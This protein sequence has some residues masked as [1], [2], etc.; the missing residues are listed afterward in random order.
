MKNTIEK[1]LNICDNENLKEFDVILSS[2]KSLSLSSQ[3]G[4]LDKYS[5]SS[6]LVAGVRV[7][8]DQ[9]VGISYSED[10][11]DEALRSMVD[12][13]CELTRYMEPNE[14]QSIIGIVK[15]TH[16]ENAKTYQPDQTSL[17][18]KTNLSLRLETEP[19]IKNKNVI[20]SPYNGY[21]EYDGQLFYGNSSGLLVSHKERSFSCY[22][23]ALIN[24]D[25]KNSLYYESHQART[26]AGLDAGF[27]I[28]ESVSK[29]QD[30]L[31]ANP[32]KTSKYQGI[33]SPSALSKLLGCFT[34]IFSG[35]AAVEGRT[36]LNGKI[37]E[38]IAHHEFT[39]VDSPHYSDGFSYVPFDSEGLIKREFSIV[40]NGIF[41]TFFHNTATAKYLKATTTASASR[42]PK[43]HLGVSLEQII[44]KPGSSQEKDLEKEPYL[45]IIDLEGLH[46][47][48]NAI[49][50]DFSLKAKGYLMKNKEVLQAFNQVTISGN[51]FELLKEIEGIGNRIHST[52]SKT[53]FCPV[54]RFS[55]LNLAGA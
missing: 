47:G 24:Q 4:S 37:G 16:Y 51:I 42:S 54:I 19:K 40:E 41:R 43:S 26:F 25:G 1:I 6:S 17:E 50:G 32:L 35:K 36:K 45:Y 12:K 48:T 52:P 27:V 23:S 38:T 30:F 7:I 18:E 44:I 28:D 49:S 8:I 10:S 11:S 22:T 15:E 2:G 39:L 46:S 9:K 21:S 3:K 13:A 34:S 14:H 20:S 53:F 29:A 5:I 33:F 31:N 55:N